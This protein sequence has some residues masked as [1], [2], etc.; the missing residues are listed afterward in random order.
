MFYFKDKFI[1]FLT[2]CLS[3]LFYSCETTQLTNKKT[4]TH[5]QIQLLETIQ[6]ED[7]PDTQENKLIKIFEFLS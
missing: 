3:L 6:E 4:L 2:F 1:I 5:N 7:D